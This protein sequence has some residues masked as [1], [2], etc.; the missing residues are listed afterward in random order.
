MWCSQMA[1]PTSHCD[2]FLIYTDGC[3]V[4]LAFPPRSISGKYVFTCRVACVGVA[5]HIAGK[6]LKNFSKAW[7]LAR[8]A[9]ASS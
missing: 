3:G 9:A 4:R 7:C 6:A 8:L 2:N 1:R 5:S